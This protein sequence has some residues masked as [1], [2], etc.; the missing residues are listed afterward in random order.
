MFDE[1]TNEHSMSIDEL[2]ELVSRGP[3]PRHIGVIPDGNRR[4]ARKRGLSLLEAYELGVKKGEIFAEWCRDL[5][6]RYLTFYTLSLENLEK[7][8]KSELDILFDLLK[9]HLIRLV[10]DERIHRDRVRVRI[11]G[12]INL[13]PEDVQDVIR[14]V[15]N[16]TKDYDQYHL[17]FLIA[18]SGRG[19]IIDAIKSILASKRDD[20]L[21]EFSEKDFRKYLY[22]SDIPDP[23]LIIRTSGE[24]RI[25]N[26][27]LWYIAYSEFYFVKKYWPEISFKD[28]LLAIR[29]YQN[30]ERRFGR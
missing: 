30:R 19:E 1:N 16:V 26:F 18:Y 27:L 21:M 24:M 12:R 15:E 8:S 9:K 22:L 4:F 11:A 5:G 3:L 14:H 17:I 23:D 6:I 29:S 2:R 7:R 25:S 10:D 13:L 28:L 20:N